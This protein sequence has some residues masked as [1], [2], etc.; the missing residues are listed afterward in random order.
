MVVVF[1]LLLAV[2]YN[3]LCTLMVHCSV[4]R[5]FSFNQFVSSLFG[6]EIEVPSVN[7]VGSRK[8]RGVRA[9]G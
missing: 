3:L 4:C 7:S 2:L 8:D 6:I 9:K 5:F 1:L